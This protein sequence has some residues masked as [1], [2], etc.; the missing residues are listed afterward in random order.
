MDHHN[1][2]L[3]IPYPLIEVE[4]Q[5]L[6]Y[7]Q[8][9][10]NDYAG[11]HGELTALTQYFYQHLISKCEFSEISEQ[12]ECIAITE[13]KHMGIL[14]EVIVLLGANPLIRTVNNRRSTFWSSCNI[15][16]TANIIRFLS[17]N[18]E[19]ERLAIRNYEQ[20]MSQI[21]DCKIQEILAR[22]IKD[23]E[24]HILIFNYF[25]KNLT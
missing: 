13:M 4:Q 16:S 21:K 1:C 5:N 24:Y 18:I 11:P 23:E 3:N 12:L 25:L 22:I 2:E 10:L 15:S 6:Q 8:L 19:A 14:G 9:L 20:H 17:E 7:A